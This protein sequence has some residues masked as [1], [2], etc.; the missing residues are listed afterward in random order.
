LNLI[1]RLRVDADLNYLYTGEQKKLGV[2]RKYDGKVDCNNLRHLTLV[3][4][5]KPGVELYSLILWSCCFKCQIRLACISEG[6]DS[7]LKK[8]NELRHS[9]VTRMGRNSLTKKSHCRTSLKTTSLD[10]TLVDEQLAL[11]NSSMLSIARPQGT[12]IFQLVRGTV[13][14]FK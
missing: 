9:Q 13:L 6:K 10:N 1:S 3:K 12:N 14:C 7:G 4:Q 11:H 5:I 8:G 2:P